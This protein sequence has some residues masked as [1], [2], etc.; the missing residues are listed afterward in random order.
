MGKISSLLEY[1]FILTFPPLFLH[2]KN[3]KEFSKLQTNNGNLIYLDDT[4]DLWVTFYIVYICYSVYE[5]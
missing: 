5:E 2:Q 3:H 1:Y 4:N